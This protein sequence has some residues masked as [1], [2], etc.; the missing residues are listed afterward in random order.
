MAQRGAHSSG[1]YVRNMNSG[2]LQKPVVSSLI[3]NDFVLRVLVKFTYFWV[4]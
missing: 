4:H 2:H 1:L 3:G